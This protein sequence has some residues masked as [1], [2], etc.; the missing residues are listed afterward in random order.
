MLFEKSRGT[1]YSHV[2]HTSFSFE[3]G[4]KSTTPNTNSNQKQTHMF[5]KFH[6]KVWCYCLTEYVAEQ[7]GG[8]FTGSA[9]SS[10]KKR[11]V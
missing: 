8:T 7:G 4:V 2:V 6:K 1:G 10:W 5:L 9:I 3:K 11:I